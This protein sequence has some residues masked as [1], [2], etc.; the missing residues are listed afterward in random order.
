MND[1]CDTCGSTA[2][3][4]NGSA[5][6]QCG[7]DRE[8]LYP[9]DAADCSRFSA[10][11]IEELLQASNNL[12]EGEEISWN[13]ARDLS[14]YFRDELD[15]TIIHYQSVLANIALAAMQGRLPAENDQVEA[16]RK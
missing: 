6:A 11:R 3:I 1:K 4:D 5:C 8:D 2:T 15:R 16:R 9:S 12:S 14:L 7:C 10:D 13:D